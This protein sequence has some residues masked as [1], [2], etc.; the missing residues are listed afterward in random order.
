MDERAGGRW[1]FEPARNAGHQVPRLCLSLPE[2]REGEG[3]E[4]SAKAKDLDNR[5]E[6]KN[7]FIFLSTKLIKLDVLFCWIN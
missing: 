1:P 2:K 5:Y 6:T 7:L 3:P 4:Y